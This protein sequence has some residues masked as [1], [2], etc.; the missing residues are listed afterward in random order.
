MTEVEVP[1]QADHAATYVLSALAPAGSSRTG[2][3]LVPSVPCSGSLLSTAGTVLCLPPIC[4]T[5]RGLGA[6]D[7]RAYAR[8]WRGQCRCLGP[9]DARL[10]AGSAR[11]A[12]SQV[13]APSLS[14]HVVFLSP[15][16]P[17]QATVLA[18]CGW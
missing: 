6:S 9:P 14:A 1:G 17:H 4:A 13:L 5:S 18:F 12:H 8:D 16:T 7:L 11:A 10:Y 15:H 3:H 2:R